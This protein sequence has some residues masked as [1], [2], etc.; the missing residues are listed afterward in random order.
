MKRAMGLW[1]G[2]AA[3]FFVVAASCQSASAVRVPPVTV[4]LN[5]SEPNYFI[6]DRALMNL[7][8]GSPWWSEA[9][10]SPG[11]TS[12]DPER[13]TDLGGVPLLGANER[14]HLQLVPPEGAYTSESVRVRCIWQGR[15]QLVA[16][17]AASRRQSGANVLSFEWPGAGG[18]PASKVWLTLSANDPAD[19]VRGI[20]CREEGAAPDI[21]IAPA[22]V[23]DL[24]GFKVVRFLDWQNTNQ[25]AP[26]SWATRP[27]AQTQFQNSQRGVAIEL[28]MA[29]ANQAGADPWF[30][31][32]WNADA[33]YMQHFAEYVRD[34]LPPGRRVYVEMSNE[35]WNSAF[36]VALQA[37]REGLKARLSSNP[38]HAQLMRY[39]EKS[40][41]MFKIWTKV[42]ERQPQR[43]VR[44]IATQHVNS[45]TA[46]AVLEFG[47]TAQWTDA[48]ATGPYFGHDLLSTPRQY[49]ADRAALFGAL[50]RGVESALVQA[51]ANRAIALRYGKR[52]IA[53]EAG[54]HIVSAQQVPLVAALNR[55]PAMAQVYRKFLNGWQ[56]RIGDLV[57]LY[58]STTPIGPYGAWGLREYAGQPT[59]Q[60]P[61]LRAVREFAASIAHP[62]ARPASKTV[63]PAN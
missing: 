17:G 48:L 37:Q 34:H 33:D 10:S 42:F 56:Q 41:W 53:Y 16:A 12:I 31:M 52:Y 40:T 63:P 25:N 58:S 59:A 26:V 7:A 9:P 54:Q 49:P 46:E 45:W 47:E 36:P 5:L 29:A 44:V 8:Q 18:G 30:T 11:W 55:D 60:A 27:T 19:R 57:M 51:T 22:Y 3:A 28:M 6:G 2:M 50:D 21:V 24:A 38:F 62:V 32:P 23:R 15:G 39:A 13:L 61:K 1:R 20:D 43:L 35:V 14:S 4:G